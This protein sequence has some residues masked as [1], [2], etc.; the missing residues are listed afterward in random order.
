[1]TEEQEI[2][3]VIDDGKRY[4]KLLED[5]TV[6]E[7]IEDLEKLAKNLALNYAFKEGTMRQRIEE[8]MIMCS[9][10]ISYVDGMVNAGKM[11]ETQLEMINNGELDTY[12]VGQ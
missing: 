4:A 9:G 6:K 11:A 7:I 2:N 8:Q 3:K 5:D 1:M 12:N 10:F